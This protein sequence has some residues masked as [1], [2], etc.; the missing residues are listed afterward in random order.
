MDDA[1]QSISS[2]TECATRTACRKSMSMMLELDSVID[3]EKKNT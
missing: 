1:I 2:T 3:S